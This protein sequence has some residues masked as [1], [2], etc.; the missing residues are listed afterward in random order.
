MI[1]HLDLEML[2]EVEVET[3]DDDYFQHGSQSFLFLIFKFHRMH[4]IYYNTEPNSHDQN[5]TSYIVIPQ[6]WLIYIRGILPY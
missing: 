3:F 1:G 2:A 6:H 5:K 4:S